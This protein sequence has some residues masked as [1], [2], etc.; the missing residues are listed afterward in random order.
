MRSPALGCA[1]IR[2][3]LNKAQR[4]SPGKALAKKKNTK[5]AGIDPAVVA[6][7]QDEQPSCFKMPCQK[8]STMVKRS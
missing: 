8:D 6:V 2:S 7:L 4:K 1:A 3:E 5:K